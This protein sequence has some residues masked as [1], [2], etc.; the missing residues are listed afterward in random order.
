MGVSVPFVA[1]AVPALAVRGVYKHSCHGHARLQD[2]QPC[3]V[4]NVLLEGR[5]TLGEGWAGESEEQY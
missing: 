1:H 4:V 3:W 5:I 2:V